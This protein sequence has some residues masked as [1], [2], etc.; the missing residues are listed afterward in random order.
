MLIYRLVYTVE[1]KGVSE[2]L[3]SRA[4]LTASAPPIRMAGIDY[5]RRAVS[6]AETESSASR[7]LVTSD[8]WHGGLG[9]K[10][11]LT[12]R[13]RNSHEPAKASSTMAGGEPD[14]GS[15][16]WERMT[17]PIHKCV[18]RTDSSDARWDRI[19]ARICLGLM[20]LARA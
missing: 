13:S 3:A 4:Y 5:S 10:V 2:G 8:H 18:K 15:R 1:H 9:V 16:S 14:T 12:H 20:D 7:S 17:F 6:M 11:V 19:A